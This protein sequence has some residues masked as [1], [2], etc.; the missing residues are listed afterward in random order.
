MRD[1][2][3][4]TQTI[5]YWYD[6]TY[7]QHAAVLGNIESLKSQAKPLEH[8]PKLLVSVVTL[9][10]IEYGHRAEAAAFATKQEAYIR[11][12]GQ[13]LPDR[14]E[15][16]EDAVPAYGEI[17]SRLF[18]KYAPREKRKRGMRSEQLTDPSTSRELGI[19][20]ND[21]WLCAQA[22]SHGMVLVTNDRMCAIRKVCN[23]MKPALLIQ[24]WTHVGEANLDDSF[25]GHD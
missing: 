18:K 8:K 14:L 19:Q 1:F 21:L 7:T 22:V 17:R 2:L 4:D 15:L 24:N 11:F 12:V 13:Q 9:G 10:E 20:E 6:D 5:A 25:A 23:S 16:T 3:L